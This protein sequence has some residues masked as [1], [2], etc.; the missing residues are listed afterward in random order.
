[1]NHEKTSFTHPLSWLKTLLKAE[2]WTVAIWASSLYLL[3]AHCPEMHWIGICCSFFVMS[4]N[5]VWNNYIYFWIL[6]LTHKGTIIAI[7][8]EQIIYSTN[9]TFFG[10]VHKFSTSK[11]LVS[12]KCVKITHWILSVTDWQPVDH[13]WTVQWSGKLELCWL[14][15]TEHNLGINSVP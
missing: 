5:H 14:V 13:S 2:L 9:A 6:P 4:I 1:M 11:W 3:V 8:A 7:R 10:F 12:G 15:L